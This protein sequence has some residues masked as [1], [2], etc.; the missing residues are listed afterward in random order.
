M[1][2][3]GSKAQ[4]TCATLGADDDLRMEYI[5]ILKRASTEITVANV[6]HLKKLATTIAQQLSDIETALDTT[7][8]TDNKTHQKWISVWQTTYTNMQHLQNDLTTK[9]K[10][11]ITK[12]KQT[13]NNNSIYSEHSLRNKQQP[14]QHPNNEHQPTQKPSTQAQTRTRPLPTHPTAQTQP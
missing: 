10:N 7:K 3:I 11:K 1:L 2:P 9:R 13:H 6:K 5:K 4:E 14:N 12:T 8:E